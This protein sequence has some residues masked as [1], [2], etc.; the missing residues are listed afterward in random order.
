MRTP[1]EKIAR[2]CARITMKQPFFGAFILRTNVVEATGPMAQRV[3][4]MATDGKTIWWN[5][6]FVGGMTDAETEGV[7]I[8]EVL[9]IVFKHHLRRKSRHPRKWNIAA[10]YVIDPI[11]LD[12][13]EVALPTGPG[14]EQHHDKKYDGQS[15]EHVYE[16][17]PDPPQSDGGSS[18]GDVLDQT[19]ADGKPLS[20]E[21]RALAETEIDQTT[22]TAADA[23]RKAGKLPGGIEQLVQKLLKP[24]VNWAEQLRRFVG[25]EQPDGYSRRRPHRAQ[26]WYGHMIEPTVER[27]GVGEL[28]ISVDV[29]GSVSDKEIEQFL[30]EMN[31][32]TEEFAPSK[33]IVIQHDSRIQ[34]VDEFEAGEVIDELRVKGRGG[35]NVQPVFQYIDEHI[36]RPDRLIL[37]TDMGIY[38]WGDDPGYPCLW[39]ATTDEKAPY[40]ETTHIKV[41]Y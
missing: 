12:I 39:V 40:G 26:Y 11:V 37:M 35:T 30:G 10:D 3:K 14:L 18:I 41:N 15:V 7:L 22:I 31:H 25:G 6:T 28:V 33:V 5:A 27:N 38:D 32:I 36:G 17:L 16:M 23:A 4:T 29:S 9:H 24:K 2:A 20:D 8:H 34:K 1:Q 13:P 21:E 19:D